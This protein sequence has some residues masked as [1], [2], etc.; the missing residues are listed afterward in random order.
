[1]K[2]H[3]EILTAAATAVMESA[4]IAA[5]CTEHF[6]RALAINVGAYPSGI[7]GENDSPFLW[8]TPSDREE[9][10]AVAADEVFVARFVVAGCVKGDAGERVIERVIRERTETENGLT[11]NG[12][13][14]IVETLRDMIAEVVINAKAGAVVSA[15]A[16]EENDLSHFPLEWATCYVTYFEPEALG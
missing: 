11:V 16:R 4:E 9:S 7:P 1:M 3:R 8:I 10:E 6:G 15:I 5:Y 12:G 14:E 2:S 13:N